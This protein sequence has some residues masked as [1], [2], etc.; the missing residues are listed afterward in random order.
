MKKNIIAFALLL[1]ALCAVSL[2]QEP[3]SKIALTPYVD[4]SIDRVPETASSALE[5]KLVSMTTANG[6]A[7]IDGEFLITAVPSVISIS[8]TPTAP[9]QFVSEVEVA[10][11]VL[12]VP[13][14]VIVDQK[15]YTFKGVGA[16]EQKAI[17]SAVN[18]INVRSTDTRRFM[19]N[20]RT[21]ILDYYDGRL[22]AI[23]AKAQS[24]SDMAQ[25]E[26]ALSVLAAVPESIDEYPQVAEMMVDVYTACIDRDARIFLTE[27]KGLLAEN[28]Y[29]GAMEALLQIDPNSTHYS[30][31]ESTVD[32][33][34]AKTEAAEAGKKAEEQSRLE[35]MMTRYREKKEQADKRYEDQLELEKMKIQ[36][37]RDMAIS[38]ASPKGKRQSKSSEERK[39]DIVKWL[40]GN[41]ID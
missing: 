36:A 22:P 35:M 4:R 34:K 16:S 24:L 27:A 14:K 6:F 39:H 23:I 28:D 32:Q 8:P 37:S 1:P 13:E 3:G 41:L 26:D 38:L 10:V 5:R 17:I 29:S 7:S 31:V 25:Y 33:I 11:Y 9:P 30:E 19:E 2:A 15:V 18:Q 20:V 40:M 12:N 21:K